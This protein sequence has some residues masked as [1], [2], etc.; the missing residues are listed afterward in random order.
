MNPFKYGCT[1]GGKSFCPRPE[2]VKRLA[3]YVKSGQNVVIQGERRMGKT[4]LVL[5]TVR[6]M[7]GYS[8]FH[9]D[10]LC[11][12]DQSDVCRRILSAV[13]RL[14]SSDAWLSKVVKAFSYLRPF[15]SIDPTTGAPTLSLDSRLASEPSTL[16]AILDTLLAQTARRKVCAVF[17]EFQDILDIGDGERILAVMRA[18]I[19]LDTDTAYVFL[20]SVRNRMTDIFWNPNCPFYH[21]A[22]SFP[23]GEIPSD[24]FFKFIRDRFASGGRTIGRESFDAITRIARAT[25]GYVQELCASAWDETGNGDVI[26]DDV[27]EKGLRAVFAREQE[28][29]EFFLRRLTPLQTRV[30]KS[31]A[32]LGGKEVF[33]SEF[34]ASSAIFNA[35]SVK[36]AI[37]RIEKEGIIYGFNGEFKFVNPFFGEWVRRSGN[38]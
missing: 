25:P 7:K 37:R 29:F 10:F 3:E 2:L 22:A 1:V 6:G 14:E 5:E 38:P 18:R 12:R 9:A 19:Q 27:I 26:D 33:S 32:T 16:D 11:V 8:L 28:H 24:D 13:A 31:L 23:V 35:S 17:D 20:G 30:L 15:V 4:S 36:G 34:L 21:S